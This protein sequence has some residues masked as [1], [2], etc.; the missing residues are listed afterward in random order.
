MHTSF[1]KPDHFATEVDGEP[2][3]VA[4][5]FPPWH[6]HQRFGIVI[7]EPLGAAGASLLI[8]AAIA[9]YFLNLPDYWHAGA[10]VVGPPDLVGTYP[11][12]YAFNVGRRGGELSAVDFWPPYKQITVEAEPTRVLHEIN[13]R[14]VTILAVPEGREEEPYFIWPEHRAFLWRTECVFSYS[15]S[16]RVAEPDI[17][18]GSLHPEAVKNTYSILDPVERV[19]VFRDFNEDR[20]EITA[21]GVTYRG[22]ELDDLKR[23]LGVVDATELEVS[24][25]E[26]AAA[27]AVKDASLTDGQVTETYRRRDAGY[28]L[29]RLVP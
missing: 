14:G 11:E 23:F 3:S 13:A 27:V 12:I 6:K 18:I 1:L 17:S 8:Q 10:N 22:N 2:T 29:R 21:E 7:Q 16:G 19:A 5:I 4:D 25:Q 20:T 26:R 24:A 9:T 28:A 15:A